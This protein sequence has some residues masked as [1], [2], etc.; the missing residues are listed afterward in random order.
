MDVGV[1]IDFSKPFWRPT[2]PST[3]PDAVFYLGEKV[4][5]EEVVNLVGSNVLTR[6]VLHPSLQ[7]QALRFLRPCVDAWY[8]EHPGFHGITCCPDL[9]GLL[10][11]LPAELREESQSKG[12]Q[13]QHQIASDSP[14]SQDPWKVRRGEVRW[15]RAEE[16]IWCAYCAV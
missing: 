12:L 13:V 5:Y 7:E 16:G 10:D 15:E 11:C 14:L 3:G 9:R 2:G 6:V 4:S 1:E 8:V